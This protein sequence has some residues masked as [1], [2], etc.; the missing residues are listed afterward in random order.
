MVELERSQCRVSPKLLEKKISDIN[1]LSLGVPLQVIEEN[2][3]LP[4]LVIKI[5]Q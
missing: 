4:E 5:E 2:F 1:T 3:S